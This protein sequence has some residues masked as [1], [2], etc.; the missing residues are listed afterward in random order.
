LT[1]RARLAGLWALMHPL[2]S[3]LTVA[4]F[5]V[6]CLIAAHGHPE[7]RALAVVALG[8]MC[9]QFAISALNDYRD[10]EIDARM[11]HKLKPIVMGRIAP[12]TALALALVLAAGMF[13]CFAPFG[14][15]V[16]A[17]ATAGLALG[18]AYD[19][20][21]KTTPFGG[22]MLGLAFPI[23]PLLAWEVFAT[24]RPALFWTFPLGM[25]VGLGIHLADALPDAEADRAAGVRGLAQM[26]GPRALATC[27]GVLALAVLLTA[28]VAG[29]R[30]V[31]AH[32][33]LL[34]ASDTLGLALIAAAA[35]TGSRDAV[36]RA[37]RLRR[38]FG[39]SVATG[40]IIAIGWL[41]A[42]IV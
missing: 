34:I 11:L 39:W 22:V 28:I 23:L 17:T 14:W 36:P 32:F 25:L 8:M 35:L 12:T 6:F 27:W 31:P 9:M 41:L 33:P 2:P 7:P 38:N 10:R 29:T 24:V 5:T 26:L 1:A 13:A 18:F 21:V 4:A 16:L 15:V 40:L 20:G 19:L 42:T 30:A 3:L 37:L